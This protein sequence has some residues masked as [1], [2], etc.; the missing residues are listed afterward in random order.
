MSN[1]RIINV[2]FAISP[3]AFL[4][5][6][7]YFSLENQLYRQ[8]FGSYGINPDCIYV[9][10]GEDA[11]IGEIGPKLTVL[12]GYVVDDRSCAFDDIIKDGNGFVLT[13]QSCTGGWKRISDSVSEFEDIEPFEI[14]VEAIDINT[15]IL[16]EV[17]HDPVTLYSCRT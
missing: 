3:F 10:L 16:Q 11:P 5:S 14:R 12:S 13:S 6:C 15:V 8:V 9:N 7:D 1:F 17:G 2:L 4:A